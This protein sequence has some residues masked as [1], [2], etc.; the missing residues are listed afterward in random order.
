MDKE[1]LTRYV[2]DRFSVSPDYPWGEE[3]GYVFRHPSNK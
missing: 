3:D 2:R 1:S